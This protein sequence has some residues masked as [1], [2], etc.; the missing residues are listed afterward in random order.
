[1]LLFFGFFFKQKTAYEMRISDWSSDVCSSDLWVETTTDLR[2]ASLH[3]GYRLKDAPTVAGGR[4]IA[5]NE[6]ELVLHFVEPAF[7]DTF[8]LRYARG[9]LAI[10]RCVTINSGDLAWQ[11]PT[12]VPTTGQDPRAREGG[13]SARGP[14]N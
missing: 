13:G 12:A 6:D 8:R 3:H 4:W 7:R 1:M 10:E 14:R 5:A 11:L 2:G 9:E